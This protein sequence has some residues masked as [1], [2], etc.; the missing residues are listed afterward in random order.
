MYGTEYFAAFE[1]WWGYAREHYV[2]IKGDR[3]DGRMTMY[4]DPLIPVHHWG[5]HEA[6]IKLG[7]AQFILPYMPEDARILFES[8]IEQLG[9]RESGEIALG[10]SQFN[11]FD[12]AYAMFL[13]KEFG[14]RPLYAKVK[15]FAEANN[16]PTWNE[17]TGEFWWAYGLDE[18]LPRGQLNA[19]AAMAEANS[20]E[21]WRGLF[22]PEN[23][24]K[25]IEP[26]VSG[27]DFP[28]LAVKQAYFDVDRGLL[29]IATDAGL[30]AAAGE[31]TSFRIDQ[32]PLGK[33]AVD[34][35]GQCSN[36]WRIVNGQVEVP[37]T[38]GSHTFVVR[39][40]Q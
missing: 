38:I 12:S 24:T 33:I 32:L 20:F 5:D 16:Q 22:R 1:R 4:Y 15:G 7:P 11:V 40:E 26:T 6:M 14:D 28:K 17:E 23:L 39:V 34:V 9:W 3:V 21:G 2:P 31:P 13:A 29:A 30:P 8:G 10:G 36:D 27:V 18:P 35:D 37:T 25:F 19:A